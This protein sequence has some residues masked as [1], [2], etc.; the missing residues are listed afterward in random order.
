M[1]S[2]KEGSW[3]EKVILC[4]SRKSR[5]VHVFGILLENLDSRS[6]VGQKEKD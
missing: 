6:N 3:G 1:Q 4:V 2:G 5:D